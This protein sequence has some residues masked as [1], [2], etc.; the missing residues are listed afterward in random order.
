MRIRFRPSP[1]FLT[2]SAALAFGIMAA[3]ALATSYD[4]GYANAPLG[5][6]VQAGALEGYK[7]RPTRHVAG[8]DYAVG[9]ADATK[10]SNGG[11]GGATINIS[12]SNDADTSGAGEAAGINGACGAAN[13]TRVPTKPVGATNLCATGKASAVAGGKKGEPWTWACAPING[14][15]RATCSAPFG[16]VITHSIVN[17]VCGAADG[18][19]VLSAPTTNLCTTGSASSESGARPFVWSCAGSG[20]GTTA[21]CSANKAATAVNGVCGMQLGDTSAIFCDT[22][23]APAGIGNRSGD[24]DGNVWGVS[25]ASGYVNFGGSMYNRWNPTPIQK[26]D[27]TTPTVTAPGDVI[28]CNGQLREASNDNNSGAFDDG[29]VTTLAMYP[30]QPFDFAGRTGTVSF[31][32]SNDSTGTHSAWPEFWMSDLPVPAPFNH[33]D[34]WQALPNNGFGIRFAAAAPVRQWGMCP[35]GNNL[36]QSRWTVDSAVVVRG[37]VMD[38]TNGLGGVHTNMKLTPLDCVTRS[39]G[40]GNMNHVELRISQ[41]QID[42]YATDA[43][44]A[45]TPT[46]LKHIAVVTNAN[47][48]LTRGLIWLEDVHYNADKGTNSGFPI[49]QRRHTFSWDNVAFDGPF[50]YRDFSYDAPDNTAAAPN[51]ALNLGKFSQANQTSS[52]SVP[53]MPANPQATAARVLFNWTG[54]AN[55]PPTVV[56][57]IVNGHSHSTPWPYP[58]QLQNTWRTFAVTIPITDLV[59]GTNVVQLGAD[60]AQ[61]F[62]NVNIVLVD[63]P[64]GV[65]VLPGSNNAYPAGGGGTAVNGACGSANGTTVSST[66][67]ANLC[68][69][70]SAS[71]VSGSGP[72]SWS[73]AGSNGGTA[74]S[75]SVNTSVQ[76]RGTFTATANCNL[77]SPA[78]CDTFNEGPSAIRGRGGDLDPSKWAVGR[79]SGEIQSSGGG[80]ANPDLVAPIPACRASFTQTSVYPPNDTLI[81]DPSGTRTSQLMTAAAIQNYGNNSY[82]IRQPFDFAGRTGKIDFDVDA[83]GATLFHVVGLGNTLGGYPEIDITED[84]VPAPTFREFTNFEVGPTP[85]NGLVL[86]FSG[87]AECPNGV[88]PLN[89]MVYSNYV[90][91]IIKPT[92]DHVKGCANTSPGSL[93]HF[94]I[95]VSQTHID[96]YGSD[97]S[98]DNGQTFPNY[99]LLYSANI[100]LPFSRGYVHVDSR[101][102]ATIKYGFGPDVVFHWD[103]IGFDGPALSAPRAYEIPDNTTALTYN[104]SPAIN[105]GYLLRDGSNGIPAGMYDPVNKINPLS[106]Q[107]VDISGITS[108]TL[109]LNAFFNAGTHTPDTNW[110]IGYR[111]NGGTWRTVN[112]TSSQVAGMSNNSG[113][114]QGITAFVINVPVTDL[115]QGTNTLEFLPVNSPMDYPPVVSN[116]DLLLGQ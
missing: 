37:Y 13:G 101:N 61:V 94:E 43:G 90:G 68:T 115:V 76:S 106:F 26:C 28:I 11:S 12:G 15:T 97:S 69:T 53:S 105:L 6:A 40:P 111:F 77:S 93:N 41:K 36:H 17:G 112:L 71:F 65:P 57:V 116:I 8:V 52:W 73:C 92:F 34:S 86:K 72:W 14:G 89:T 42:V 67:T 46:T 62:S 1:S 64:G 38:D 109:T 74:A 22:F 30:K 45:A 33:F 83:I 59:A 104:G 108:A 7:A 39:S 32:V 98:A 82:M 51:G 27:G 100:N 18:T 58:D 50:T 96:V 99:K 79:I 25:R 84:P 87:F 66:P 23:D 35:N 107:N 10:T 29:G 9:V 31:D 48:T 95:Q 70:G 56:N 21:F 103:N 54:E 110:G 5:A 75:C 88:A 114:P 16:R 2:V 4:D 55:P 49:S 3:S 80:T 102:H 85:K 20:G 44:V 47:L 91:T 19:T 60:T 81:C 24:L 78:F 63:V 113:G